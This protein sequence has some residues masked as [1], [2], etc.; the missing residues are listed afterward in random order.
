M[1]LTDLLTQAVRQGPERPFLLYEDHETSYRVFFNEVNDLADV[2]RG[3]GIDRGQRVAS[4]LPNDFRLLH[5]W[6]A[7][8]R[9]GAV[10]VPLNPNLA[11][12]EVVAILEHSGASVLIGDDLD[13]QALKEL[14]A[15]DVQLS[16]FNADERGAFQIRLLLG[17]VSVT[18]LNV[19]HEEAISSILYTSGT[20]GKPKGVMLTSSSY[21]TPA[22]AF[23]SWLK[24][25]R[26]DRFLCCL[27]LFHMAGAAFVISAVAAGA[28]VALVER[29]SARN[30][31]RQ[32]R[33]YKATVSRYLGEMLAV[34][35]L[36]PSGTD[37]KNHSLRAFYGG[38]ARREIAEEF[39]RRFG[40]KVVEGYGL[41]ETNT[42]L[43]NELNTRKTGS[44][45]RPVPYYAVRVADHDGTVLPPFK[46]GEI[47]VRRNPVMM[48]GY[49]RD[50]E[51]TNKSFIGPWFRTGDIGYRDPDGH[52]Y[53]VARQKDII[54]RR[55]ENITP[56]EIEQVLIEHPGVE[57]AAV[58]G[59]D[60]EV[61][62]QEIKAYVVRCDCSVSSD[63]LL[64]WCGD[65]LAPFK[66]PRFLEL[67]DELPRTATNK[68]DKGALKRQAAASAH[69]APGAWT[70]RPERGL[71]RT[72]SHAV[73]TVV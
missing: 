59:V 65:R 51:L 6:F 1:K 25:R 52:V 32:V 60:D 31:W 49:F 7:L 10:F 34:L 46:E 23:V 33:T 19:D 44:I 40:A 43:R 22:Q 68:V 21:T 36:Q 39:E 17:P 69:P 50:R 70:G 64:S 56:A 45:G 13:S 4:L 2:L 71:D 9:L 35:C 47:Q 14:F 26:D 57:E 73:E 72:P 28:S 54:R 30:F 37:E 29:F 66:V 5:L 12:K 67:C 62:G 41:S 48:K 42:V 3:Q 18:E 24:I 53:F 11:D 20:T 63:L 38:G 16:L 15:R 8:D 58:I 27:P 55:G 61:G